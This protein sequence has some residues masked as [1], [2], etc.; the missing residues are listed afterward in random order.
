MNRRVLTALVGSLAAIGLLAGCSNDTLAQDYLD[1]GNSNYITGQDI[2]EVP[3]AQ[4]G[5]PIVF[6]GET[7]EGATLMRSDFDGDVVVV[8]FWYAG[9]APCRAEAPDLEALAQQYDGNGASFVGVNIYDGPETSLAFARKFGISYPS[10]L[11][12]RTGT[13]RLA[14]AGDIPPQAVPT[15]FIL[16]KQGRIAARILGQLQERSILDTIVR[17]LVAED[18]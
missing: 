17:D 2:L 18:S 15:T 12:A 10:L 4:R 6:E 11:D 14:F 1:G 3:A 9:C 16:D 5:D 7:D 13:I 8:N